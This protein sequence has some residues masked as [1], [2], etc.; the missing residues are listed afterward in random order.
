MS[1]LPPPFSV[2]FLGR[3]KKKSGKQ[4]DKNWSHKCRINRF[5]STLPRCLLWCLA[6]I[7]D[8]RSLLHAGH[9]SSIYD[10]IKV[11]Q[12]RLEPSSPVYAITFRLGLQ[13]C[14]Y[15][16]ELTQHKMGKTSRSE[17]CW[18]I[19]SFKSLS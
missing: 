13:S 5:G 1:K 8:I 16:C 9:C 12:I 7:S 14:H 2:L 6:V 18:S 11:V 10:F 19:C 15:S 17:R 3:K 4:K